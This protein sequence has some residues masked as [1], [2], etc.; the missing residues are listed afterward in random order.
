MNKIQLVDNV[1]SKKKLDDKI[2][3]NTS[4]ADNFLNVHNLEFIILENT[5]L[6]IEYLNNDET[7]L[8]IIFKIKPNVKFNLFETRQGSK[9]KI[10]YKFFLEENAL[11]NVTKFH[12]VRGLK[13]MDIFYL[14]G[15]GATI[16]YNFKTISSDKE[17][18]DMMV[19]HNASK[20]NSHIKNSGVNIEKGNLIFNVSSFVP[21]GNVACNVNQ[22]GKIINLTDNKCQINPNLLIDENDVVALH[23]A[24]IEKF[25]EE[26]MFYLQSRG[27]YEKQVL[28][29]LIKGFL[30]EG[31]TFNK[32]T[33]NKIINNYWKEDL[34]TEKILKF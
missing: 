31:I 18:Y 22:S 5:N 20:T 7:K 1:I 33:I 30:L 16:N 28:N 26:V 3:F 19:Y 10:Q 2:V 34:W 11:A 17:K 6:E 4:S 13:E 32:K 9:G 29:L 27:I 14:N 21:N 23:A 15:K 25:S 24:N 12:H 8:A